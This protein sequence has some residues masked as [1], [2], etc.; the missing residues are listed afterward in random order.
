MPPILLVWVVWVCPFLTGRTFSFFAPKILIA[1]RMCPSNFPQISNIL[2]PDQTGRISRLT[3]PLERRSPPPRPHIA[4]LQFGLTR[5]VHTP[6]LAGAPPTPPPRHTLPPHGHSSILVWRRTYG[7][8]PRPVSWVR[9][10][11][12]LRRYRPHSF[13]AVCD[14]HY[15]K[16]G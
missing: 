1:Y 2:T 4:V 3:P 13:Y 8:V 7:V 9:V 6:V 12:L 11:L 14:A 5:T 10:R 16:N 15:K